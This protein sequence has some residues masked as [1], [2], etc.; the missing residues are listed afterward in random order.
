[1]NLTVAQKKEA[2]K[3]LK[4]FLDEYGDNYHKE[5]LLYIKENFEEALDNEINN[6]LFNQIFYATGILEHKFNL[7]DLH[8]KEIQK[9]YDINCNILEVG[10]GYYPAFSRTVELVQTKGRIT[11][12]DP[13]LIVSKLGKIELVKKRFCMQTNIDDYDLICAIMPCEATELVIKQANKNNKDLYLALCGDTHFKNSPHGY[14]YL[15]YNYWVEHLIE[16]SEKTLP[17][18]RNMEVFTIDN[19]IYPEYPIIKTKKK[20]LI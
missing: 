6:D 9:D 14:S 13:E 5:I 15:S 1:M 4:I 18:D 12:Y 20:L 19:D 2:Y 11:T 3:K 16:L 17:S 8:L 7:Y 10:G